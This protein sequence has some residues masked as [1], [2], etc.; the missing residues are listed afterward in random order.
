[1]S[2]GVSNIWFTQNFSKY[3][4]IN[5]GHDRTNRRTIWEVIDKIQRR[6]V[7]WK[8]RPLNKAGQLCLVKSVL[9]SILLYQMQVTHLNLYGMIIGPLLKSLVPKSPMFTLASL[10]TPL[11]MFCTMASGCLIILLPLCPKIDV[12]SSKILCPL[13]MVFRTR[14]GIGN[15]HLRSLTLQNL[16]TCRLLIENFSGIVMEI[17]AGSGGCISLKRIAQELLKFGNYL[18]H[19]FLILIPLVLLFP[20]SEMLQLVTFTS[21]PLAFGGFGEVDVRRPLIL[22]ILGPL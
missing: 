14:T 7:V 3:L 17:G 21:N 13:S 22:V 8:G 12:F 20:S 6:L 10:T 5:I 19:Q 15:Q 4:E 11:R 16:L 18:I 9:S 1:M 2:A